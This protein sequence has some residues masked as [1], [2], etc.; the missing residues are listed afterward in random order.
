MKTSCPALFARE[1]PGAAGAGMSA[2]GAGGRWPREL[3]GADAVVGGPP[4][5]DQHLGCPEGGE[6]LRSSSSSRS[7]LLKLATKPFSQGLSGS[8]KRGR[9]P[10]GRARPA[11]PG[12]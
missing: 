8:M 3:C 11:P 1:C 12:W 6:D 9:V 2:A 10:T 7:L 4:V 5:L